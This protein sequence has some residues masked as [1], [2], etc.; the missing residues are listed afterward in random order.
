MVIPDWNLP[1]SAEQPEVPDAATRS[2][3]APLP[4]ATNSRPPEVPGTRDDATSADIA[5]RKPA[6]GDRDVTECNEHLVSR[7]ELGLPARFGNYELLARIG[8]GGMGV[9]WKARLVG[10]DR[11]VALKQVLAHQFA[12]PVVL[13]RFKA[14]ARAAA[15]LDHPG[16]VPVYDIGEVQGQPYYT[17]PLVSGGN[18]KDLLADGPLHPQLAS[19]LVRQVAEA[20][21]HA[22]ARGVVH[23]DLKPENI[24]LQPDPQLPS[25]SNVLPAPSTPTLRAASAATPRLTDFGLARAAETGAGGMT[26]TGAVLGTPPY[27]APEQAAGDGKRVG[28]LSDVYGLGAVLYC[29]LTGRPPFQAA[30]PMETL[31]QVLEQEPAPPRR[32]NRAVPRDLETVCLKCLEKEPAKRYATA[33]ELAE[34]LRRY[35]AD[36]PVR[37][38]P[39]GTVGRV[40]KWARRRPGV[41]ALLL[42]LAL[43][44]VSGAAGMIW[45]YG[46]AIAA[47]DRARTE[48][49]R[50]DERTVE[51]LAAREESRRR[52]YD[53]NLLVLQN[54]WDQHQYP[55]F[56]D[57]LRTQELR[58]D[59]QDIRG[60][61]WHYWRKQLKRNR[62]VFQGP[63]NT[64]TGVSF[65]RDGRLLA[66]WSSDGI[67]RAW[68]AK[69]GKEVFNLKGNLS[70]IRGVSFAPD[71]RRLVVLC[72]DGTVSLWDTT[73]GR[74]V[75][76]FNG[77][78]AALSDGDERFP[79]EA[80]VRFSNDGRHLL[81]TFAA[82]VKVRNAESGQAILSLRARSGDVNPSFICNDR[83]IVSWSAGERVKVCDAETGEELLSLKGPDGRPKTLGTERDGG[84]LVAW[85]FEGNMKAWD[86]ETGQEIAD[87]KKGEILFNQNGRRVVA[88]SADQTVKVWDLATGTHNVLLK[89]NPGVVSGA[90]LSNDGGRVALWY[91]NEVVS[92]SDT[93]TGR[94]IFNVRAHDVERLE[95][96]FAPDARRMVLRTPDGAITVLNAETG[97]EIFTAKGPEGE[98]AHVYFT[99]EGRRLVSRTTDGKVKVWDA[100]TGKLSIDSKEADRSFWKVGASPDDRRLFWLTQNGAVRVWDA[101]TGNVILDLKETGGKVRR[102]EF[103]PNCR[104]LVSA[105]DGLVQVWDTETGKEILSLRI[106]G[107]T[108][109][110][111]DPRND[112]RFVSSTADGV[113]KVWDSAT[114]K[115]ILCLKG[116]TGP[117]TQVDFSPDGG[118]LVS[119]SKDK[120][121]KVWDA[122]T[123]KEFLSLNEP[124]SAMT[125]N[126]NPGGPY[127]VEWLSDGTFKVWK[128]ARGKEAATLKGTLGGNETAVRL[129]PD[130][131]RLASASAD[132]Q[133]YVWDVATGRGELT[134][135]GYA[136]ERGAVALSA[137]G[138]LLAAKY[139]DT[140][141]RVCDAVT[142]GESRILKGHTA[143]VV[144]VGFSPDSRRVVS[145]SEDGTVR[146]W[147]AATGREQRTLQVH[148]PA[149]VCV[150]FSPDG[151]RLA[152]GGGSLRGGF[153]EV[154]LWDA[155]EVRS[156][157]LT[158]HTGVVTDVSF[159]PD[160]RRLASA[161]EDGT[162]R[163]WDVSTGHAAAVLTG[164]LDGIT[165]I[166]FS[167]DGQRLV[168]GSHDRTVKV[169]DAATGQEV[170]TLQ[171]HTD[172][173]TGVRFGPDGRRLA[174][175]SRDRTIKLWDATDE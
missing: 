115:Q 148:T 90:A 160:G 17:M 59:Q 40:G 142:G 1:M 171:G 110:C 128:P 114:G 173:V 122:Q 76:S 86:A 41:A 4:A 153:G 168:S 88:R 156:T 24:L 133:V 18:L 39:V 70:F 72:R 127:L 20:V 85:T 63:S 83:R 60:F 77:S 87:V 9:V 95:V 22:H 97:K 75:D 8:S 48:K 120:T 55:R 84:P 61:E 32:L 175:T 47:A 52:E 135:K 172:A 123:G 38:H 53:A 102:I 89:A 57:L 96:S 170:L 125:E 159:S 108:L 33:S 104:R 54:L 138:R 12:S 109:H 101:E 150:C 45:A 23:R 29:C 14:E 13:N 130:G 166:D 78:D 74:L 137:D 80:S 147:D 7:A 35:S 79:A 136:G 98:S 119:R 16:I 62:L 91:E 81:A 82:A 155:E 21:S 126:S 146:L 164:N 129:S 31:R 94:E 107:V 3:P 131:R 34:D 117:V 68:D 151:R 93:G 157:I 66:S 27:M 100:Q 10:T 163:L 169:W 132:G 99:P 28:P 149:V 116:H 42:F 92:V 139:D 11:V 43:A 174:S 36:E 113:V 44:I 124:V 67:V 165:S 105:T 73:T 106:P 51:A 69:T 111:I 118:H 103:C 140:T 5:R 30:T 144:F 141:M 37:A 6:A 56:V 154:E 58:E 71:G 49:D 19:V 158:G 25:G 162:I 145:A 46:E 143:S 65:S 152:W 161:S 50:A 112:G 64:A 167:P 121:M 26:R 134:L 2:N 15:G